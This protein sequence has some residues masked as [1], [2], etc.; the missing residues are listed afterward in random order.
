MN[1]WGGGKLSG[2]SVATTLA[3]GT[4]GTNAGDGVW[5]ATSSVAS[6]LVKEED[7]SSSEGTVVSSG[8]EG[9][10]NVGC[11]GAKGAAGVAGE[12]SSSLSG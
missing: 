6:A 4:S 7:C 1:I 12:G 10:D 8:G 11:I 3:H 5:M 2:W 9:G